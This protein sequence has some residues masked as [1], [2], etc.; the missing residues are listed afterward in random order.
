MTE[1]PE[2]VM[3][4][5]EPGDTSYVGESWH[6]D[7]TMCAEPPMGLTPRQRLR[8]GVH[9]ASRRVLGRISSSAIRLI[10]RPSMASTPRTNVLAIS[11]ATSGVG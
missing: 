5:R 4:R 7:T 1:D 9:A 3:V 2:V 11:D 6:T 8:H 10:M